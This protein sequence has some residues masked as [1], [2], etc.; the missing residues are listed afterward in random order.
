M[1]HIKKPNRLVES[2]QTDT[3]DIFTSLQF[4]FGTGKL[5]RIVNRKRESTGS[6]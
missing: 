3:V 1:I 5:G 6:C 2:V 4:T